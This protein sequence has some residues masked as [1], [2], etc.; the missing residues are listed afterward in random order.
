MVPILTLEYRNISQESLFTLL[1]VGIKVSK[2]MDSLLLQ[3]KM[4]PAAAI[5][6]FFLHQ[7]IPFSRF[8]LPMPMVPPT[9]MTGEYTFISAA[10]LPLKMT[11]SPPIWYPTSEQ[12]VAASNIITSA[13]VLMSSS[14]P[15]LWYPQVHTIVRMYT[16]SR[17]LC[18]R[19]TAD[20]STACTIAHRVC[21]P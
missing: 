14:Y 6:V 19:D 4:D 13:I 1:C 20:N 10:L 12:H 18:T 15:Y 8:N 17:R 2:G 7:P 5:F 3:F 9:S 21:R 11:R 16:A